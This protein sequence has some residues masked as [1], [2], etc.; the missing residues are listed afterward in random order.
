MFSFNIIL[1][2][3]R[4]KGLNITVLECASLIKFHFDCLVQ[5]RFFS[6]SQ[7]KVIRQLDMVSYFVVLPDSTVLKKWPSIGAQVIG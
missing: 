3:N 6:P 2:R 4:S 7:N 1:Y 5:L